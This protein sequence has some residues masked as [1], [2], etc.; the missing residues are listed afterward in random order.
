MVRQEIRIKNYLNRILRIEAIEKEFFISAIY[1]YYLILG[2]IL[3]KK[4]LK[5]YEKEN[6]DNL[7]EDFKKKN[8]QTN[9]K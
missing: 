2:I 6:V 3:E 5:E 9:G 8:I 4:L 7:I 1:E